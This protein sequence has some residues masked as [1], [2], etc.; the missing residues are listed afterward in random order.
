MRLAFL[1]LAAALLLVVA[2]VAASF[3]WL[4]DPVLAAI[5]AIAGLAGSLGGAFAYAVSREGD[6][7][8]AW[9]PDRQPE[10]AVA[11]AGPIVVPRAPVRIQ[12]LPVAD[13]PPA[14]L[15][16]VMKGVHA[17][18]TPQSARVLPEEGLRH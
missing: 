13:L 14:Y 3:V 9:E 12:S 15:A 18:R 10:P 4:H 16:A 7:A 11:P 6:G 5:L 8:A 17:N 1:L 2:A